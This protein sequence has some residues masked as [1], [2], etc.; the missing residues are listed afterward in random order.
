M[1]SSAEPASESKNASGPR[2]TV[3]R[4]PLA[5]APP[6]KEPILPLATIAMITKPTRLKSS[7]QSF[8]IFKEK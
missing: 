5:S 3:A 2:N 7:A 4:N 8:E 1:T 6:A